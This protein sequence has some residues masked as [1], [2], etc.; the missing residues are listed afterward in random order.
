VAAAVEV[1]N[2][3]EICKGKPLNAVTLTC[4][5]AFLAPLCMMGICNARHQ[6]V[7]VYEYVEICKYWRYNRRLCDG[8]SVTSTL[9]YTSG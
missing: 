4:C 5:L 2:L 6:K 9:P 8:I 3:N 7:Q 1:Q